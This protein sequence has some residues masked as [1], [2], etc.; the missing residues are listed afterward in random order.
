MH[1]QEAV[2]KELEKLAKS[3]HLEK[4]K[5]VD[6]ASFVSPVVLTVKNDKSVKIALNSRKSSDSCVNFLPHKPKTEELPNQI[7]V[8]TT[9][10]RAEELM[11]SKIDLAYAYNQM[12]LSEETTRQCVFAITG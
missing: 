6:E 10:D 12:G 2:G 11:I 3:G 5:Q 1:L 4:V 7:S 8:G 9:N